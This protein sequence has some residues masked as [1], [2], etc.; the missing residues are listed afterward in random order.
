MKNKIFMLGFVLLLM[1]S[2]VACGSSSNNTPATEQKE[3]V[4][5]PQ[6]EEKVE[7]EVATERTIEYLGEKYTVPA[8]VERIVITGAMEA[9][10]DSLVLDVHPVGAITFAG[11]FPEMFKSITVNAESIGEKIQPNFETILKLKPDVILGTSKFQAEV[12]EQ[13]QKIAPLIQVSHI[14]ANWEANL[15]L[16]GELTDKQDLADQKIAEYKAN[17]EDAK[18]NLVEKLEGKK[19]LAVRV[20]RGSFNVYP[21][22]VFVN[23]VLYTDLGLEAPE[24]VKAA[25]AQQAISVE[26][27]AEVNPDY[28]FIQFSESENTDN[29]NALKELQENPIIK[30]MKAFKDGNVFV[31]VIDPLCE[32]GPAWSRIQFLDAVLENVGK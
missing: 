31:N 7:E 18:A 3:P 28:L 16:L 19:V 5:Q 22:A 9:M 30:N 25:T 6:A 21:E 10:E 14:A 17:L 8:K 2:V 11:E 29:P 26:Q 23:P 24:V 32:G 27:F 12:V 13:L 20:R 1:L 4:E 15:Q